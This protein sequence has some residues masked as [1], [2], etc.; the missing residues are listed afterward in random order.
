[1]QENMEQT[2]ILPE[3]THSDESATDNESTVSVGKFAN[4]EELLKAYNSLQSEFTKK[5]QQ[6]RALEARSETPPAASEADGSAPLYAGE[7]WD[8]R[9]A[10]FVERYP[11]ARE[12]AAEISEVLKED[13][14]LAK[15]S[16]CL[17]VALGRAVAKHYRT[18]ES[19]ME[20]GEFLDRYVLSNGK[21]RDKV[22]EDYLRELSPLGD[23]PKTIP[24]GGSAAII[25]PSRARSIE[26]AGAMME[27]MLKDRRI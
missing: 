17:E 6:L 9:V 8:D 11:I 19:M 2:A 13:P 27:K 22:I 4:S 1:M 26:E 16:G 14:E 7:E 24:H 25:P 3:E 12:Y 10:D 15:Q 18:P 20:D 21:V 23:A 5:C